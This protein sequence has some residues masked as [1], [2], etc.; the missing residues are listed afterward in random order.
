[1]HDQLM[2]VQFPHCGVEHSPS[3]DKMP[4]NT[5]PHAR[6]F[7]RAEG[8]YLSEG[9][10]FSGAFAFWG[11]WEPPSAI[12]TQWH[13][14]AAGMPHFLYA[15]MMQRPAPGTWRQNSDPLVFGDQFHYS[16]CRQRRNKKLR[17]LA[18]GSLILFGSKLKGGFVLD[19]VFVVGPSKRYSIKN[20]DRSHYSN[21]LLDA[22]LD[23]LQSDPKA[24]SADLHLY[25]G[26]GYETSVDTPFS[27]VPC[28]PLG[29]DAA[30]FCRPRIQ[31][32]PRWMNPSLSMAAKATVATDDELSDI[33]HSVTQQVTEDH[34]LD[35]GV[36]LT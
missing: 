15:P 28:K 14:P 34:Q 7:L 5:G 21:E 36:H 27:Y 20:F 31:L 11:E 30:G 32:P 13:R 23:P 4:W 18:A 22:V 24:G 9:R 26:L 35:L 6:K 19:T 1:M 8:Q 17:A 3:G 16:N 29:D 12:L 25:Q 2:F 10:L 33:W